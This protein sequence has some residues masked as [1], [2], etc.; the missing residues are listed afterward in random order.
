L[1]AK[2]VLLFTVLV[3]VLV[4]TMACGR[5]GKEEPTPTG[6]P[7]PTPFS[8]Q[9]IPDQIKPAVPGQRCVF[10]VVVV[11]EAEDSGK[12]EPVNIS[13]TVSGATVAVEPQVAPPGLVAEVTVIPDEGTLDKTL[14]VTIR[15]ERHGLQHTERVDIVMWDGPLPEGILEG[16]LEGA[17]RKRDL[18]IPWLAA[19]YPDLGITAETEWVGTYAKVL[20]PVANY[21][22]FF[23]KEWEMVLVF[24]VMIPPDDWSYIYL[25]HRFTEVCPSYAFE[26]SSLAA[27]GDPRALICPRCGDS[28]P[29]GRHLSLEGLGIPEASRIRRENVGDDAPRYASSRRVGV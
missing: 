26:I 17:A 14:P 7:T 4:S 5:D 13:A 27:H 22:L 18:F 11:A 16:A 29:K 24:H 9:V 6:T 10:L 8:M 19:N 12:G 23:S 28:R 21:Y 20:M 15:S 25:R 1:K 2:E 3:A